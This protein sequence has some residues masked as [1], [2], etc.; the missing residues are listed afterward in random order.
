MKSMCCNN[1]LNKM[2]KELYNKI[3]ASQQISKTWETLISL[4]TRLEVQ[5]PGVSREPLE[6]RTSQSQKIYLDNSGTL[7]EAKYENQQQKFKPWDQ[8]G[9]YSG[10]SLKHNR[11]IYKNLDTDAIIHYQCYKKGYISKDCQNPPLPHM[12]STNNSEQKKNSES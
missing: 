1:L 10:A 12:S 9:W 3:V 8:E 7:S 4:V 6:H 11:L 2:Q 5:L